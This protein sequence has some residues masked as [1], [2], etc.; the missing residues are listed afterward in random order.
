[1]A[2]QPR[3]RQREEL[4]EEYRVWAQLCQDKHGLPWPIHLD[5][6]DSA[7]SQEILLEVKKLKVLGRTPHE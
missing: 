5:E 7:S 1:M 6:L 2:Q 3:D 4:V